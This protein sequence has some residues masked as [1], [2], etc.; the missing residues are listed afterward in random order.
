MY[1]INHDTNHMIFNF[2]HSPKKAGLAQEI[3]ILLV[4][5][6]AGFEDKEGNTMQ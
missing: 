5:K 3:K 1:Y 4:L 2:P 6:P